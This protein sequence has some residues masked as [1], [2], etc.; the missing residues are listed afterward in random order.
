ML[1]RDCHVVAVCQPWVAVLAAVAVMAEAGNRPQPRSMTLMAGPIDA[2]INPTKVNEL[3]TTKPIEWFERNLISTVPGALSRRH[4]AGLSRLRPARLV[5]ADEHG[6]ACEGVPR[7]VR[8]PRRRRGR[9]RRRSIRTFYDEYLAVMDLPAEFFIQTVRTVFQEHSLPK[10]ELK[11]HGRP[12]NPAAIRRTALFT[13]EGENDDICAVGQTLA[14]QEL[15]QRPAAPSEST[16]ISR[17]APAI[18]ACS[19][20]GAGPIRSI[21][22]CSMIIQQNG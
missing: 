20:G 6:P 7:H 15:V 22:C 10:G 21:R 17:P 2:R 9:E 4:A 5:H 19:T 3:A 18:T 12:V 16:T 8:I 13:V 11:W 1:G 14:A